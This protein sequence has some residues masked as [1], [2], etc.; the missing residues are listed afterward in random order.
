MCQWT[1]I[2]IY[3]F[4]LWR[5]VSFPLAPL[6]HGHL[7]PSPALQFLLLFPWITGNCVLGN[8]RKKP[9]LLV[10]LPL[11]G[12]LPHFLLS[13]CC[14]R[15]LFLWT[16]GTDRAYPWCY[17][18]G[19]LQTYWGRDTCFIFWRDLAVET[20][21]SL[22]YTCLCSPVLVQRGRLRICFTCAVSFDSHNRRPL[23]LRGL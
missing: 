18:G 4:S 16:G 1:C 15:S 3:I 11:Y 2:P 12:C 6:G 13:E 17:V 22:R 9:K 5:K 8:S 10:V 20:L 23:D 21:F 19:D 14:Y 7:G